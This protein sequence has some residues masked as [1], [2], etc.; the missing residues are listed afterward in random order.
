M[1]VERKFIQN[2]L[3]KAQMTEYFARQLDRA[4][5][6]GMNIT[7]T[8][9]G[10]QITIFAEKPG[11]II[12]KGGRTIRR[13]TQDMETLFRVDNPQ[14]DVQEVKVPELNAKMMASRLASAIERGLYFRK[15]GTNMLR[16]IMD[17][18]ALGCEI[19]IAG[20]LTGPRKRTQ[21]FVEGNIL[22][23]GKPAEE[24]VDEGFAIA[25]KKLG[26]IGCR[27]RI[28]QPNTKLPGRFTIQKIP[29]V[30]PEEKVE[31]PGVQVPAEA[32]AGAPKMEAPEKPGVAREATRVHEGT[33]E[34]K[35]EGYDY[36]HPVV[37]I[38]KEEKKEKMGVD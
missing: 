18:G 24:L 35:H 7:R 5:Y 1:G 33:G 13:L 8:P 12:G 26:I 6:G 29:E 19:D 34:H 22:H 21:K 9:M 38:H 11:M 3:T 20:K 17:A 2:G 37:R 28:V 36:W 25:V 15:A 32:P 4:G 10:T 27:V 16:R 23:S 30:K 14:I 31:K